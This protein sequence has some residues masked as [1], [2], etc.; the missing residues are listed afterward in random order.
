MSRPFSLERLVEVRFLYAA[1][2]FH[3]SN[4]GCHIE[5]A[6]GLTACTADGAEAETGA[7]GGEDRFGLI[8]PSRRLL[9]RTKPVRGWL[10]CRESVP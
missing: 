8:L 2:Y 3:F 9:G 4:R 10:Q 6:I 5:A 1:G 7:T